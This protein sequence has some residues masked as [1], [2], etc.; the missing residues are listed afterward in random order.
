M[1]ISALSIHTTVIRLLFPSPVGMGCP[2]LPL[3]MFGQRLPFT[4]KLY[5]WGCDIYTWWKE[6]HF[7]H[8]WTKL[9]KIPY[10]SANEKARVLSGHLLPPSQQLD[11]VGGCCSSSLSP[12][13][14]HS[15]H[16]G[17]TQV[18]HTVQ[19]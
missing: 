1:V 12:F 3:C 15:G 19:R 10:N 5:F 14:P 8:F 9:H 6:R 11:A 13:S 17:A 4:T 7:S 16:P 2:T 18:T